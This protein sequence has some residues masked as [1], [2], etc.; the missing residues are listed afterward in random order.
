M[1][2]KLSTKEKIEITIQSGLQMVPYVGGP[3]A[4]AYFGTKQEKRFK[5]LESFYQE[6]SELISK[7]Q[8]QIL[9]V[10]EHDEKCLIALI[11]RLNDAIEK[12]HSDTKRSMFKRFFI[13]SLSTATIEANYDER[14]IF[15]DAL[16]EI[17]VTE[18]K[19]LLEYYN[20]KPTNLDLSNPVI[21]GAKARLE[22]RGFLVSKQHAIT[23]TGISPI[24]T[25]TRISSFGK[26]FVEFCTQ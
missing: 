20:D 17:T 12:E 23:T 22:M 2:D 8:P 15:L 25:V 4:T 13:N 26:S 7:L 3:L 18:V 19:V 16:A 10:T 1:N 9:P 14:Q 21:L 6:L 5:R 11:E 24:N